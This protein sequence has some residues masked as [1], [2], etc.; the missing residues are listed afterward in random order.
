MSGLTEPPDGF[1]ADEL[2]KALAAQ[3]R[4]THSL[5][6]LVR[7]SDTVREAKPVLKH[8]ENMLASSLSCDSRSHDA[9]RKPRQLINAILDALA[10]VDEPNSVIGTNPPAKA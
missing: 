4:A 5:K 9:D 2:S 10:A 8:F 6:R 7:L 3:M 1:G